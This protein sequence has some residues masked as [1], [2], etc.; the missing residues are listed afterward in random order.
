MAVDEVFGCASQNDLPRD[1]DSGIFLEADGGLFLIAVV[2]DDC[3]TGL[4]NTGLAA[5]V[6][7]VLKLREG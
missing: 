5:L 3:D 1:T 7:Q 6:D 2:E 4:G